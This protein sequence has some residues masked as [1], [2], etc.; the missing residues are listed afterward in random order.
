MAL[1]RQ[2]VDVGADEQ[3]RA[4]VNTYG[5]GAVTDAGQRQPSCRR[6]TICVLAARHH[7]NV[8]PQMIS[9]THLNADNRYLY[10]I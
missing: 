9:T 2:Q 5:A 10:K 3:L 1:A 4:Q 7:E 6:S 8:C